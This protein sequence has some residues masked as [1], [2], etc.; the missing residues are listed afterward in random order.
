MERKEICEGKDQKAKSENTI[1]ETPFNKR[2]T[3]RE[4]ENH[5][6]CGRKE[7]RKL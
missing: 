3:E 4:R 7:P 1:Q 5:K 6:L 2:K